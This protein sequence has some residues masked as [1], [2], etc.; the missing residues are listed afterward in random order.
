M[1]AVLEIADGRHTGEHLDNRGR[2][3][4]HRATASQAGD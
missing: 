2:A 3:Q 4:G 1:M